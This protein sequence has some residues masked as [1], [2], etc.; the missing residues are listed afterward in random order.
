MTLQRKRKPATFSGDAEFLAEQ[1]AATATMMWTVAERMEYFAGFDP[2]ARARAGRVAAWS[3]ILGTWAS[4][5]REQA[6][7]QKGGG[8]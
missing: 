3:V 5:V 6:N 4:Y 2:N 1:M 7:N 8:K